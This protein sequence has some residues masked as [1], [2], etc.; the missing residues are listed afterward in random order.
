M[1]L[2]IGSVYTVRRGLKALFTLSMSVDFLISMALIGALSLGKFV[3]AAALAFL[4]G[5]AELMEEWSMIKAQS[6]LKELMEMSPNEATVRRD[7]EERTVPVE[8]IRVGETVIVRPG[9]RIATDGTVVE[10]ETTVNESAVTGESMPES[11]SPGD[12]VFAGTIN[13]EG[14]VEVEVTRPADE[15]T[16]SKI[17]EL[18]R[19]AEETKAPSQ[20]FVDR[21]ASV[22][23][24]VVVSIALMLGTVVPFVP[25]VPGD[26]TTWWLRAMALLVIACP[27]GL[28]ISTPVTVVSGI[29]SAAR[30][31]TL[32][33]GG[34]P[35]E[36]LGQ[37]NVV[38]FDKTGTLTQGE[39]TVSEIHSTDS[40]SEDEIFRIATALESRSEHHL[41]RAI[42]DYAVQRGVEAPDVTEF[43]SVT[44]TGVRAQLDGTVYQVGKPSMFEEDEP[45]V[46]SRMEREAKTAVCVGT[47]EEIK[48]V[49]GISDTIRSGAKSMIEDLHELGIEVVMITGD[50]EKT[51]RAVAE[52]LSIDH[53]HAELMPEDKVEEIKSLRERHG[54]I[55]MVGDG[56]N[57]APALAA[58]DVGIAMGAAGT[59]TALETSDIALLGDN[60]SR[61]PYVIRLSRMGE[62]IIGQNIW[63]SVI[64]KVLLGLGVI[65]GWVNLIV[66]VL[67][68]DMA[69]CFGITGNAMRLR[70]IVPETTAS[71]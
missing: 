42:V 16:L 10:G 47:R 46:A 45:D 36:T 17:I 56:V 22:Y 65:P 49:I 50:N 35:F 3:E 41:A 6:S 19:E 59:D 64:I 13:E 27:C 37:L 54:R 55:A 58:A 12:D 2:L 62:T 34:E 51:A 21:F 15:N 5:V 11:K 48:G 30:H 68:G 8:E 23:T 60:L 71:D 70:G 32:I 43:E 24:P 38:C 18:I 4:Y 29:T 1:T 44:A 67:V 31:G 28:L 57:D 25:G 26:F 53:Y 40:T 14:Y 20:R 9:D 69:V 39:P 66:A 7:G 63:S 61:L 52:K 33:K